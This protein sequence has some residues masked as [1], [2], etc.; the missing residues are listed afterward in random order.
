MVAFLLCPHCKEIV[1]EAPAE[2]VSALRT[3]VVELEA[4]I[5]E[6]RRDQGD[7]RKGVELIA[8]GL[9]EKDPP[10]LSCVRIA[11]KALQLRAV[12]EGLQAQ[13]VSES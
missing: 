13:S 6:L 7:W 12:L 5:A 2:E 1:C 11:E 3:Q 4:T 10:N 9:G 8:A